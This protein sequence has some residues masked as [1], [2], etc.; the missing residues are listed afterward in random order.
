MPSRLLI[1]TSSF[2][3]PDWVG[4]FYPAGMKPS[5]FLRHYATIYPTVEIDATYYAIPSKRTV[6]GWVD[7]TPESFV[8]AAK[9][10]KSIVHGG[11]GPKPNPSKV[12]SPDYAYG[13]RDAFLE[14]MSLL[15]PRLGP[16][17]IQFPYFSREAFSSASQFLDKL[18]PFLAGLP[19]SMRFAVEIRNSRWLSPHL[20]E[21]LRSHNVALTLTDQA[22]MPHG[23]EIA[24][25]CE[26]ITTHF[27]YIRLIG[28]RE[29]IEKITT[30]WDKEVIDR[31]ER[32]SR[33][34]ALLHDLRAKEINCVVYVNNH[35]AGHAP[36]TINRLQKMLD[37][38]T[39]D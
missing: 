18:D 4:P 5:E 22:W 8:M 35:F 13:E 17:V 9:F 38:P 39:L 7:K 14:I 19:D 32:L 20:S 29:E 2:S 36:T 11:D 21:L 12:L 30:R 16:M 31:S 27:S 23:D 28:D 10:P 3:E 15:G 24:K 1:G 26:P 37:E 33:W 25:L 6:L 34:A